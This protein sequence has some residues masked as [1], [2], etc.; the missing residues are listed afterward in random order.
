MRA[1]LLLATAALLGPACVLPPSA[2]RAEPDSQL[3][4]GLVTL[5]VEGG[6]YIID[7]YTESCFLTIYGGSDGLVAVP[8]DKLK[9]NLPKAAEYLPWVP[10]A[11]PASDAATPAS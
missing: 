5:Y 11:P 10:D 3:K 2:Q 9:R 8:C 6:R 7:P 1:L 4:T